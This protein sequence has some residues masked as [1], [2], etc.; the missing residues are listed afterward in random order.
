VAEGD[1]GKGQKDEEDEEEHE[2]EEKGAG[3]A[4]E[5]HGDDKMHED[6]KS[7]EEEEGGKA[8][9]QQK[10]K[11]SCAVSQ[12]DDDVETEGGC[13][14]KETKKQ[15]RVSASVD[16]F[17]KEASEK[18]FL[19]SQVF[20]KKLISDE[21]GKEGQNAKLKKKNTELLAKVEVLKTTNQD[22]IA[23]NK[24]LKELLSNE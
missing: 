10:S 3:G 19:T 6:D 16:K 23:R 20:M 15:K 22:F 7:E 13:S 8:S 14:V 24:R 11:K 21:F 9:K 5:N 1:K 17:C 18:L 12:S 2:E 4:T